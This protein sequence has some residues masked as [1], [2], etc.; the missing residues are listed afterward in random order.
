LAE[1]ATADKEEL[2]E[3]REAAVFDGLRGF[4]AAELEELLEAVRSGRG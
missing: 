3:L 4:A 2:I 1:P